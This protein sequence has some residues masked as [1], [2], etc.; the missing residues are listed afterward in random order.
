MSEVSKSLIVTFDALNLVKGIKSVGGPDKQVYYIESN[1]FAPDRRITPL[2]LQPYLLVEDPHEIIPNGDKVSELS[3]AKW[4]FDEIK[5]ENRITAK[6]ESASIDTPFALGANNSLHIRK[7]V[8]KAI[9]LFFEAEYLDIRKNKNIHITL[10]YLLTTTQSSEVKPA[11]KLKL[12]KPQSWK[13]CP[14]DKIT[15]ATIEA[16]VF[17]DNK[18]YKSAVEWCKVEG[19][20]VTPLSNEPFV[21][22]G[23]NT[24]KL[25]VNPS[26]MKDSLILARNPS[27][28]DYNKAYGINPD[29]D[30]RMSEVFE[31]RNIIIS[32]Y[33][34]YGGID[35]NGNLTSLNT[36]IRTSYYIPVES[37]VKYYVQLEKIEGTGKGYGVNFF[38]ANKTATAKQIWWSANVDK[39]YEFTT[40]PDCKYVMFNCFPALPLNTKIIMSTKAI[41]TYTPAPEDLNYQNCLINGDFRNGTNNWKISGGTIVARNEHVTS[42][43]SGIYLGC[44]T[45]QEYPIISGDKY[46]LRA[47]MKSLNSLCEKFELRIGTNTVTAVNK[48]LENVKYLASAILTHTSSNRNFEIIHTYSSKEVSSTN[49]SCEIS[50]TM[51]FN[52]T[53]IFGSGNEPSKEILDSVFANKA[54]IPNPQDYAPDGIIPGEYQS[55]IKFTKYF[56]EINAEIL[57]LTGDSIRPEHKTVKAQAIFTTNKEPITNPSEFFDIEWFIDSIEA[58]GVPK[59]IGTGEFMEIPVSDLQ[60]KGGR[61]VPIR[62]K[63][64]FK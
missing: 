16:E 20:K 29:W 43:T 25:K 38:D 49:Q 14:L 64:N 57:F 5:S 1:I 42:T 53:Q 40:S 34:V 50:N 24:D 44:S 3:S 32:P 59:Q 51:C 35:S 23:Q 6:E 18:G 31:N 46:Y 54:Y 60:L 4:Y 26:L 10:T 55:D 47:N 61:L 28:A 48:P 7:N 45:Y 39:S 9:Q 12:S 13:Y 27:E 41:K 2:I 56:P 19:D 63:Y 15:E 30:D 37:N 21:L 8:E 36:S 52:L 11:P 62:L 33:W 17:A 58:G 22:G